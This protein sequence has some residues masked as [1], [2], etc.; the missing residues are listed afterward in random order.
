MKKE[1]KSVLIACV[2]GDGYISHYKNSKTCGLEIS[3]TEP[4]KEYLEWKAE[5]LK[6]CLGK[7]IEIKQKDIA[8][9][10]IY[11]DRIINRNSVFRFHV[12][13]KYFRI[14]R[15][16]IYPNGKKNY[17]PYIKYLTPLGLAIWYMDDG[18]LYKEKNR[19][20]VATIEIAT[21]LPLEDVNEIIKWFKE[22]HDIDFYP[23]KRKEDQYNIRC[24]TK[25]SWKFRNLIAKYIPACM[26]Y[27]IDFPECYFQ[28]RIAF[29][30]K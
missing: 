23:H 16:W 3:H 2:I 5:L 14:L 24:Y 4:Q 1:K 30:N 21:H 27:K 17:V 9:K 15:K 11:K 25:N 19:P 6:R 26:S 7:K 8:K 13:H 28:E 29:R 10:V 12:F 20:V 22:T 18:C